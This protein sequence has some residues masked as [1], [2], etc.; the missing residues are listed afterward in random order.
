MLS[1]NSFKVSVH[2]YILN[3][4]SELQNNC[5][6]F[7]KFIIFSC[8]G[9]KM[10]S[11]WFCEEKLRVM[12]NVQNSKHKSKW[13]MTNQ[14]TSSIRAL[15]E[16][17]IFPQLVKKFSAFYG[18]RMCLTVLTRARHVSLTWARSISP[19]PFHIIPLTLILKLPSHLCLR[20]VLVPQVP[21]PKPYL[22]LSS[23][24]SLTYTLPLHCFLFDNRNNK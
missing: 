1:Q 22:Y 8:N 15:L 24:P 10:R 9:I 12:P 18:K 20:S 4:M 5:T 11:R 19:H 17:L 3:G 13:K 2:T 6:D 23:I 7:D 21:Q 14:P 16:K